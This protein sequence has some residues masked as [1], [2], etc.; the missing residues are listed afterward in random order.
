MVQML[1]NPL[2]LEKLPCSAFVE[3]GNY[4]IFHLLS[5]YHNQIPGVLRN[6]WKKWNYSGPGKNIFSIPELSLPGNR[7]AV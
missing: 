1:K 5:Q 4:S 3:R 2:L 6:R 7:G